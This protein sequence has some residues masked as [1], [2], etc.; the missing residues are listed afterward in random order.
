MSR[1]ALS[2]WQLIAPFD[3]QGQFLSHC[4]WPLLSDC[5]VL[6]AMTANRA[7]M[8]QLPFLAVR[9]SFA[10]SELLL[11]DAQPRYRPRISSV[12]GAQPETLAAALARLQ[13]VTS[14]EL[15]GCTL[16]ATDEWTVPL[17]PSLVHLR[18]SVSEPVWQQLQSMPLPSALQELVVLHDEW[19]SVSGPLPP[20]VHTLTVRTPN[21][22]WR[23]FQRRHLTAD[24][25]QLRSLTVAA[26]TD[27]DDNIRRVN[28]SLLPRSLTL[29]DLSDCDYNQSLS[30]L[31]LPSLVILRLGRSL[32]LNVDGFRS[33]LTAESF[34]GLPV[35]RELDLWNTLCFVAPLPAGA[36]PDTLTDLSLPLTYLLPVFVGVLPASLQRLQIAHGRVDVANEEQGTVLVE[37]CLPA[38]LHTF[39]VEQRGRKHFHVDSLPYSRHLSILPASLVELRLHNHSFNQSLDPLIDLPHLA[40]LSI[41][42]YNFRQPLEPISQLARL[43]RLSLAIPFP[44]P[45]P[46]LPTQL[47]HLTIRPAIVEGGGFTCDAPLVGYTHSLT[48]Q[49]FALCTQLE[50]VSIDADVFDAY[51]AACTSV[52]WHR[53]TDD[54]PLFHAPIAQHVLPESLQRLRLPQHYPQAVDAHAVPTHCNVWKGGQRVR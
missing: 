44:Q 21:W 1:P 4:L 20:H 29:L 19:I 18:L 2:L 22:N 37:G 17:P 10:L 23:S 52:D 36:L 39:A 25:T 14:L 46:V 9:H 50:S 40:T 43:H 54:C 42:S 33:S 3:H 34:A 6:Q 47:R 15:D 31:H 12:T 49:Q 35:L 32:S 26:P 51:T 16:P 48:A 24:S 30:V 28:G 27:A 8:A 5:D 53:P 11:P 45:L 7:T 13:H 38:G 41:D